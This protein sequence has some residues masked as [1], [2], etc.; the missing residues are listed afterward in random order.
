MRTVS[1][2]VLALSLLGCGARAA[3]RPDPGDVNFGKPA[4]ISQELF[5]TVRAQC[6]VR[7]RDD[8]DMRAYCERKQFDAI[9]R[10]RGD[11]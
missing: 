7:W 4:D 8:F 6:V 5:A 2:A 3:E 10:L 11:K 9:R 1:I